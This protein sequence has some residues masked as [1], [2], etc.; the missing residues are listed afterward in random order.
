MATEMQQLEIEMVQGMYPDTFIHV[1][2]EPPAYAIGFSASVDDPIE[3]K[4]TITYSDPNYPEE[5]GLPAL[6]VENMSKERRLPVEKIRSELQAIAEE[7]AGMHCAVVLLQ[8]CQD[9]LTTFVQEEEKVLLQKRGDALSAAST[10]AV[11]VDNTIRVGNAVTKE[12][13]LEWQKKHLTEKA[14]VR[15][16]LLKKNFKESAS[17]LSGRQLWDSTIRNADWELFDSGD[18]DAVDLDDAGFEYALEEEEEENFD[19]TEGGEAANE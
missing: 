9:F 3:L 7:H 13:F 4:L 14:A 8:H 2:D 1:S 5:G 6:V 11:V 19:D 15:A 12:N 10:T 17:K 18:G 16:E